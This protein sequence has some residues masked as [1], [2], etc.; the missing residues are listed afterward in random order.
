MKKFIMAVALVFCMAVSP[1]VAD[2]PYKLIVD[3]TPIGPP[4][5]FVE[6]TAYVPIRVV[7][8]VFNA[9]TDWKPK[10]R[11]IDVT[12]KPVDIKEIKRPPIKGDKEFTEKINAALDLLEKKDFPHYLLV[13]QNTWEI[14]QVKVK[15]EWVA[16]NSLAQSVYGTTVIMP[17]LTSDPK[18]YTPVH[19][20]GIL[21]HEAC[22]NTVTNYN[23]EQSE[24]LCYTH[25]LAAL[26]LLGAPQWIKD[27]AE[28]GIKN[29]N[30]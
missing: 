14:N 6:D 1:A 28:W 17:F 26:E 15:P 13:C 22:H 4:V 19:L 18:L 21:V 3:G 24:K 11:I 23:R 16:D 27:N 10:E 2:V 8:D 7:A 30:N 29:Y 9:T 5:V 12:T 25:E 20:A